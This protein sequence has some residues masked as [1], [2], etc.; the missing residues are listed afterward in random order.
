[1]LDGVKLRGKGL[2]NDPLFKASCPSLP[3]LVF[4]DGNS[5][6]FRPL[7]NQCGRV[8]LLGPRARPLKQTL[9]GFHRR[10]Q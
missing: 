5:F 10:S 4:N 9:R 1:M 7:L 6:F 8:R 3:P 2:S